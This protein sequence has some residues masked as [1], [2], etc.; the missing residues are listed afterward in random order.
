MH[1]TIEEGKVTANPLFAKGLF[2]GKEGFGVLAGG[3]RL[4]AQHAG[5]FAYALG[6]GG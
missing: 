5:D 1:K 4:S 2:S 6:A 3:F